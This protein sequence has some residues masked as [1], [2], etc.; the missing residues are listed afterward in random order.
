MRSSMIV[1]LPRSLA[2][3]LAVALLAVAGPARAAEE[4]GLTV[5]A[6]ANLRPALEAIVSAFR[7]RNPGVEV[8]VIYGASGT[9]LAQI[10]NGAPFDLFLSADADYPAAV[11]DKGLADGKAFTYAF[12]KLA[13]WTPNGV[14]IDLAGRGLAALDDP[15]VKKI[16]IANPA[17]APYGRAARA[18]LERAGVL[19]KLG[20][21]LV[22]GQSVSQAAQFAEVGAA[23]AALLPVSLATT[24][25]LSGRGKAW[26]VPADLYAPVEQA[27]V[28]IR[29]A[30]RAEEARA[31][32][33]FL[34]TDEAR[35]VLLR[36][37]YGL[38]AR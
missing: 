33:R 3:L 31:L 20:D 30:K 14:S 13:V 12:G 29:G 17:V 27:G 16:A 2:R 32:A 19:G 36:F 10:Q 21:R 22:L 5:A 34:S 23:Q 11:V 8:G 24:P 4:R 26:L 38:P 28:V 35:N 18:A 1:A 37:G 6:A 9:F 25:P 15:A 7:A